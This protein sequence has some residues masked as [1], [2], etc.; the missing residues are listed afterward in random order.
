LPRRVQISFQDFAQKMFELRPKNTAKKPNTKFIVLFSMI[1]LKR[2]YNKAE[3]DDGFRVLVD[4]LW[5]RGVSKEEAKLDLW[6]KEIAPSSDLRKWFNH[7][8]K[9]WKEFKEKYKK[10]VLENKQAFDKLKQVIKKNK[11]VTLLYGVKDE[12]CSEAIVLK[13]LLK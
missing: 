2:I 4:R 8:P 9:K 10:E 1:K 7:D 6:L 11:I 5:P 12:R 3:K 13:E